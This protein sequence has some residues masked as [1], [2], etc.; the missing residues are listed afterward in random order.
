MSGWWTRFVG[1]SRNG[2]I[3]VE[4]SHAQ[5]M[6][7][8]RTAQAPFPDNE[9]GQAYW[10]RNGTFHTLNRGKRSLT[11][12]FRSEAALSILRR[13]VQVSDVVLENFT[14][15]VMRRFGLDY[16]SLR[17]LKPDL[18]MASN[19][20]YGHSGPWS[21]FGAMASALE[22]VHGTGAFMGYLERGPDGRLAEG[23]IPNKIGNSYTD[24]L[25][26]WTALFAVMACLI[27]R[28]RTGRGNWID[29]AMYQVGVSFVGEGLLDFAFNGRRTR[30]LGNRHR[31]MA[32]HGCY[33][34]RGAD[35]WVAVAVRH[36]ADWGALCEA[37]GRPS[38][39]ADPRFADILARRRSQEDLDAIISAWTS[40][41]DQYQV[42]EELQSRGV[43]AGPVFNARAML[44]DPHF[45]ARGF[46]EAVDHP[47]GLGLGRREYMGRGWK[48]SGNDLH[49]R[50]PAPILGEA[51]GYVLH[52][53]LGLPREEIDLLNRSGVVGAAPVGGGPPEVVPLGRQVELGWLV[54]HHPGR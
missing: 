19:T 13:L 40:C 27:Y 2:S 18:I 20:G 26:T 49:I 53:I 37:L 14:P 31:Q 33:P 8:T 21:D 47:P 51:N 42:M 17:A 32:P 41:R 9:P 23:S 10:E 52:D 7:T 35:E 39:A 54:E 44:S 29:L 1:R 34:C 16:P 3:K 12:D 28:S 24:F 22:P 38:L 15:R 36:D 48:L 5:F 11:L 30:R 25:A 6:E 50:R 46:F 45:R 43:P 4:S